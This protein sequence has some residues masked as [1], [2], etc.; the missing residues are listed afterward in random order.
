[1][2]TTKLHACTGKRCSDT[3][4]VMKNGHTLRVHVY[5]VHDGDCEMPTVVSSSEA[6][7]G[8]KQFEWACA[9]R[10]S[11][12]KGCQGQ[13]LVPQ[14]RYSK[15]GSPTKGEAKDYLLPSSQH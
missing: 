3:S 13:A 4:C 9:T 8:H 12:S 14:K 2:L 7:P 10:E 15:K 11:C 1:M 5:L 6:H